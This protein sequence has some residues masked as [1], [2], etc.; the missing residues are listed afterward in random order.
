VTG[1]DEIG[2]GG[3]AT[4]GGGSEASASSC[5]HGEDV[6]EGKEWP[7]RVLTTT[8]CPGG[9]CSTAGGSGTAVRRRPEA[10]AA[11]AA[12]AGA[13]ARVRGVSGCGLGERGAGGAAA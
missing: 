13:V 7:V 12:A 5:G 2:C 1:D 10:R 4:A 8:G 6:G 3:G 9:G 11:K